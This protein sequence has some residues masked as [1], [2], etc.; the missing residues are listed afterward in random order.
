[1]EHDLF[2][3]Y[4]SQFGKARQRR[5][6]SLIRDFGDLSLAERDYRYQV[7]EIQQSLYC[8][9]LLAALQV[10]VGL[11]EL[12]IRDLVAQSEMS[13]PDAQLS[14]EQATPQGE[15]AFKLIQL[16]E[17]RRLTFSIMLKRLRRV[18]EP[19]DAREALRFYEDVRIPLSHGLLIRFSQ[20]PDDRRFMVDFLLD[21]ADEFE[22]SIEDNALRDLAFIVE[23]IGRYQG[24]RARTQ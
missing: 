2:R 20:R 14:A 5:I 1:M 18:I 9:L 6:E 13:S 12:F 8:G 17:D 4:T 16:E 23:F 7:Y 21:R 10:S 3:P 15:R 22:E 11:F 24:Q 19:K